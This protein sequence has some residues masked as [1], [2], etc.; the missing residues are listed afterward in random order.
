[1]SEGKSRICLKG[2]SNSQ[3]TS[4]C[5][6]ATCLVPDNSTDNLSECM[7]E[8]TKK[9]ACYSWGEKILGKLH[10]RISEGSI[11]ITSLRVMIHGYAK[12]N[13]KGKGNDMIQENLTYIKKYS[14]IVHQPVTISAP[15]YSFAIEVGKIENKSVNRIEKVSAV[16]QQKIKIGL[17][18]E[19]DFGMDSVYD[20]YDV[21]EDLL[22]MYIE[23]SCVNK[24]DK[25]I[26]IPPVAPSTPTTRV[27]NGHPN[28]NARATLR[29]KSQLGRLSLSS[30][31]S[32]L[33]ISSGSTLQRLMIVSYSFNFR[34]RTGGVDVIDITVPVVIGTVPYVDFLNSDVSDDPRDN[35]I[36]KFSRH[37]KAISLLDQ[38]ERSLS[39]KAQLQHLNKYPFYAELPTSSKQSKKLTV[40]ANKIRTEAKVMHT[41]QE[42]VNEDFCQMFNVLKLLLSVS[43]VQSVIPPEY[44]E[45]STDLLIFT[46]KWP[47]RIAYSFQ[48]Q[49]AYLIGAKFGRLHNHS[50]YDIPLQYA[51]PGDACSPLIN[52]VSTKTIMLMDRGNCPFIDKVMNAQN[53]G[54][55]VALVTD[56][57]G[58]G[59]D[60]V[61]MLTDTTL[62][63]A[64]IPAAFVSGST[65]RILR[66]TLRSEDVLIGSIPT[67]NVHPIFDHVRKAPWEDW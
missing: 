14:E 47:L 8:L 56:T 2:Q 64:D 37:D 38:K 46:V 12:V 29:R 62:R 48:M 51:N 54:A 16:L 35:P 33:S 58:G 13:C 52:D 26:H 39:N 28:G 50:H 18:V 40:V 57:E 4:E 22:A 6:K 1:M 41:M 43:V 27:M 60:Y 15:E 5:S 25:M 24:I 11:E 36:F 21:Q 67:T 65:G 9:E 44:E 59:N 3:S 42:I 17:D 23:E 10:L 53:A 49:P 19:N 30:Q 32:C 20:V 45:I 63:Q 34:V 7:I 31:K 55:V 66:Q 61:F